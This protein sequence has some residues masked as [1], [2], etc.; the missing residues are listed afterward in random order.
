MAGKGALTLTDRGGTTGVHTL[1][2][3]GARL[4]WVIN[5]PGEFS[6][7]VAEETARRWGA[8]GDNWL[9][10]KWAYYRHPDLPVWGGVISSMP[11]TP[12]Q[13]EPGAHSFHVL[14]KKRRVH[15]N[16]RQQSATA[17]ALA[18][19]A[20]SDVQSDDPTGI[21]EFRADECGPP[22]NYQWRGGDLMDDVLP[23]LARASGQEYDVDA[24]RIV[25][26]RER[27]GS[28]KSGTVCL[29]YPH[30]IF[31]YVYDPDL[32]TV[33]NDIEGVGAD[34]KYENA[35][36]AQADDDDS[37][38]LRG[39]YMGFRKYTDVKGKMTVRPRILRELHQ[40][41]NPVQVITAR[42]TQ[43][44]HPHLWRKYHIGDSVL[45]SL[46]GPSILRVCR[47]EARSVDVDAGV[48]TLAMVIE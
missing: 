5:G 2:H 22:I 46:P 33:E 29:R 28:D 17:G 38:R 39:R 3:G 1:E 32:W 41:R 27:L 24:D 23:A 34:D 14:M 8:Q 10:S 12:G 42:T 11:W 48:E 20:H 31:D 37:I 44:A 6:C 26:W 7:V 47:I 18:A 25:Y 35:T 36:Y 30:E 40:L 21:V 45:V 16:Y 9:G 13:T 4:S 15:R 43:A 19:R